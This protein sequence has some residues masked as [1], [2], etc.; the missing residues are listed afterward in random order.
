MFIA[1]A[2][3]WIL[4]GALLGGTLSSASVVVAAPA[5]GAPKV[6]QASSAIVR[7]DA[8]HVAALWHVLTKSDADEQELIEMYCGGVS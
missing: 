6:G 4:C 7:L 1:K 5:Q 2:E 8:H 3:K